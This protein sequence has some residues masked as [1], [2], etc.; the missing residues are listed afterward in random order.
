MSED[1]LISEAAGVLTIALNRPERKNALTVEVNAQIIDALRAVTEKPTVRVVVLTG[2]GGSFCSGLDLKAAMQQGVVSGTDV[3]ERGRK[4]FHGMI[5]AVRAAP[6]PVI[7]AVDGVAAGYGCDLALACDL[8]VLSDRARFGEI[9]VHR[10]LM[11][12][13]GGT[14]TLPRLC[15]LGRALDIL[16]TGELVEAEE[17]LRIGL[18]TRLFLSSNFAD[19]V[20]SFAAK[21]AKGPPLV[22]KAI[23]EAVY[24]SLYSSFDDALERELRGQLALLKTAD[25]MEGVASFLQKREPNFKGQ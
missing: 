2:N 19:S 14:F 15:G 6:M 10:G 20:Q 1:V 12:D 22:F 24:A 11:P 5:R 7:A 25:F 4:Y 9:F 3:E 18:G 21:M 16:F 23:K 17:A 8:R 13:G